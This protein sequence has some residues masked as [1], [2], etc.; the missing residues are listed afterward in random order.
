MLS[1]KKPIIEMKVIGFCYAL[2]VQRREGEDIKTP[3][4]VAKVLEEN[5][6]MSIVQENISSMGTI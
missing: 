4:K 1:E 2:I 5:K 6:D 3:T